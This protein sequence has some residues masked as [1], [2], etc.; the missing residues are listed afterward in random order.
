MSMPVIKASNTSRPQSVTDMIES[1][2][3][4]QTALSHILNAEGEKIQKVLESCSTFELSRENHLRVYDFVYHGVT[5]YCGFVVGGIQ[6][7]IFQLTD[8]ISG[9]NTLV[10]C[11]DVQTVIQVGDIIIR[12]FFYREAQISA[13]KML[14]EFALFC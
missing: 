3:L 11:F 14:I 9:L 12:R 13:M 8:S 4:E 6:T 5:P 2:A 7:V 10:Y 1:I